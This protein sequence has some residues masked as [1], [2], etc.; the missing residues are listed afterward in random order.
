MPMLCNRRF[1]YFS[2]YI[3]TDHSTYNDHLSPDACCVLNVREIRF[4]TADSFESDRRHSP[5]F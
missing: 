4:F 3:K 2:L 1:I 5:T